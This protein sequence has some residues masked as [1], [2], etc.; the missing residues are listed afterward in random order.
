MQN[1]K[2]GRPQRNSHL[3]V[4]VNGT[5]CTQR[6]RTVIKICR[7]AEHK[8]NVNVYGTREISRINDGQIDANGQKSTNVNA[9]QRITRNEQKAV[10][11]VRTD[12]GRNGNQE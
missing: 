3:T 11:N 9:T 10:I 12:A 7:T 5:V 1:R 8:C 4:C 6:G 2:R